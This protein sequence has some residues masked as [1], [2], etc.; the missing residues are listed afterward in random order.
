M[1]RRIT[2]V[3]P[4]VDRGPGIYQGGDDRKRRRVGHG[5][6]QE[7]PVP[8]RQHPRIGATNQRRFFREKPA[9]SVHIVPLDPVQRS[10]EARV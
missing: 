8:V 9:Q 7:R 10:L 1:Q 6:V 4:D 3:V 2:L 5:F